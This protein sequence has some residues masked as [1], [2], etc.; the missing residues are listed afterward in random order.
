MY[1]TISLAPDH[2]YELAEVW[3]A[4]A[5]SFPAN[6]PVILNYLY[7]VT[8]LSHEALLPY[9]SDLLCRRF[10]LALISFVAF[11]RSVLA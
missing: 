10:K 1:L 9:V 2:E 11:R 7:V 3:R 6:L 4:L 8:V 5:L